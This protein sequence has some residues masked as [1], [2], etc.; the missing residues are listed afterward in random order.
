[1]IPKVLSYFENSNS[2]GLSIEAE[3]I[4]NKNSKASKTFEFL[5]TKNSIA[6]AIRPDE[7]D[8][9]ANIVF[10]LMRQ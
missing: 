5:S 7:P 10:Q 3:K 4:L 6:P 2:M 9:L 1:L 8:V